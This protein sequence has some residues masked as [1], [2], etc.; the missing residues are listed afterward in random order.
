MRDVKIKL[1]I[2]FICCLGLMA[3]GKGTEDQESLPTTTIDSG[4]YVYM[5]EFWALDPL[6]GISGEQYMVR[7]ILPTTKDLYYAVKTY[8]ADSN[9]YMNYRSYNDFAKLNRIPTNVLQATGAPFV[10]IFMEEG[11]ENFYIL[12]SDYI[13]AEEE[14]YDYLSKITYNKITQS[15]IS[16]YKVSLDELWANKWNSFLGTMWWIRK[17]IFMDFPTVSFMSLMQKAI[18]REL[19]SGK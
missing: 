9:A 10:D 14:S 8:G 18:C 13:A 1:F 16:E 15:Y 6:E 11:E 4:E 12:W 3:C 2:L 5:P 19:L 17:E 7:S